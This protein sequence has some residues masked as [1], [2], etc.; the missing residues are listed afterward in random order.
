ALDH[1]FITADPA[2]AAMLDAGIV[3]PSWTRT[4]VIWHAWAAA[5]DRSS[6]RPVC[7]FFGTPGV[8]PNSH[9][10]TADASECALVKQN[11]GWA[12]EGIAFYID[13]PQVGAC[14]AGT[15]PIYRSFYAGATVAASNHRFLPDL[16]MHEAMAPPSLLEGAVMCAPL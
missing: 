16:T 14:A 5:A 4:G 12:F 11:P 15:E 8:G 10:Y 9:F 7:R 2:E 6:A 1:Y 13:V 3:V